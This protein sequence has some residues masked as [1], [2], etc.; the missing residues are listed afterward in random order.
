MCVATTASLPSAGRHA[1]LKG[2]S[3]AVCLQG[4]RFGVEATCCRT[5]RRQR[6]DTRLMHRIQLQVRPSA[7]CRCLPSCWSSLQH[8]S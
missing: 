2:V 8:S 3:A 7:L 6:R 5:E 1:G 4:S